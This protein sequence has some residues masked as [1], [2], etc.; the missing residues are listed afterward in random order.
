V[1]GSNDV[2]GSVAAL[3]DHATAGE[4]RSLEGLTAALER[5]RGRRIE[6]VDVD[7]LPLAVCGRWSSAPTHD[8]LSLRQGLP[9]RNWTLAHELGHVMLGHKGR[10]IA[11]ADVMAADMSLVEYMLNRGG[12]DDDA[13]SRQEEEAEAFAGLLMTR[14][15][16]A[17]R[18]SAPNV[19]ARLSDTLG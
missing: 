8:T 14:M 13:D 18:S 5:S 15:R 16:M 10:P 7:D 12:D 4:A 3:F 9:S 2:A 1:S 19:Q 6:I 11:A 17:G